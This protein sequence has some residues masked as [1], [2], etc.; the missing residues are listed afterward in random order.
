LL[1]L[2]RPWT[3]AAVAFPFFI[4]GLVLLARGDH[5]TRIRLVLT[6]VLSGLVASLYF[7]WQFAVTGD[8]LTNPYTLWWPYDRVGF[9]PG[10]GVSPQGHTFGQAIFHT[11]FSLNI[12]NSDMFGWPHLAWLF[13]PFGLWAIRRDRRI[14]LVAA[15]LPSLI[16]AYLAYWTPAGAYGPRYYYEG[17]FVPILLTAAGIRW[18]AGGRV[19]QSPGLTWGTPARLRLAVTAGIT[20]LLIAGNLLFYLPMRMESLTNIYGVSTECTRSLIMNLQRVPGPT[21]VFVHVQQRYFEYACL[22]DMNSPFLDSEAVIAISRGNEIDQAVAKSFP[23][24]TVWHYYPDTR[25]LHQQPREIPPKSDLQA[26]PA[27]EDVQ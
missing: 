14:W 22:I 4:H 24:R 20:M 15:V 2:T 6:G 23:E 5:A 9:G 16:I 1:A 10:V 3:A 13:L 25:R 7:V 8:L 11:M 26:P 21:L 27:G 17:L 12:G 18:L 19:G